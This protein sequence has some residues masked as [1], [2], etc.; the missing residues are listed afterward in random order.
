MS[1]AAPLAAGGG[2]VLGAAVSDAAPLAAGAGDRSSESSSS[3]SY[4]YSYSSSDPPGT[5][6]GGSLLV[7]LPLAAA[8]AGSD[9]ADPPGTALEAPAVRT[10]VN[11]A[12]EGAVMS[13]FAAAPAA[14]GG[15][16]PSTFASVASIMG[17]VLG[18]T[19][20]DAL[21]LA[22]KA[23]SWAALKA[24]GDGAPPK[25]APSLL[26]L[27]RFF[28]SAMRSSMSSSSAR[29]CAVEGEGV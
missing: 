14:G 26:W 5:A 15:A 22:L 7:G 25:T 2:A 10:P 29:A 4:S 19:A 20:A 3:Y 28:A 16:V 17:A 11:V 21:C 18:G 6:L 23:L 24:S 12:C 27:K 13:T 9:A 1:D 8:A